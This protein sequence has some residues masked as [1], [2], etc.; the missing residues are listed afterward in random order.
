MKALIPYYFGE[1]DFIFKVAPLTIPK[2]KT[3]LNRSL[4]LIC[5]GLLKYVSTKLVDYHNHVSEYG[6]HWNFFFTMGIVQSFCG[7]L[8]SR[9]DRKNIIFLAILLGIG[10]EMLL[11]KFHYHWIFKFTTE[12]RFDSSIW[13]ANIEGSDEVG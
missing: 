13:L 6:I 7:S 5:L 2:W 1:T 12:Q 8:T 3:H 11:H 4:I 10:H 9:F